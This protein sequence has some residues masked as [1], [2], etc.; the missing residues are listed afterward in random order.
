[1][2]LIIA[3][4]IITGNLFLISCRKTRSCSCTYDKTTT[5]VVTPRG[6]PQP[7]TE[8]NTA[9]GDTKNT[10]ADVKKS[11]LTRLY[12][13]NSRVENTANTYTDVLVIQ[14][15]TVIG[16]TTTTIPKTYTVDVVSKTEWDYT[17]EVK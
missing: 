5:E 15:Q 6:T 3:I 12:D 14:T 11:D 10:V 8:I 4:L 16:T 13:C 2:K 9:S 1:M 7:T 17:C